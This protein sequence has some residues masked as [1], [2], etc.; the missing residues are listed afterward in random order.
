MYSPKDT[1]SGNILFN[2][3]PI[4]SAISKCVLIN[5]K[6]SSST[7]TLTLDFWG[8]GHHHAAFNAKRGLKAKHV[9]RY[10]KIKHEDWVMLKG[11]KQMRLS[12]VERTRGAASPVAS[13]GS[14]SHPASHLFRR[15]ALLL[16]PVWSSWKTSHMVLKVLQENLFL[17]FLVLGR[18]SQPFYTA[19]GGRVHEL[20]WCFPSILNKSLGYLGMFYS[21]DKLPKHPGR[22]YLQQLQ[23]HFH[24]LWRAVP[25]LL[26]PFYVWYLPESSGWD[27]FPCR[28]GRVLM[29]PVK[30]DLMYFKTF[31]TREQITA[32]KPT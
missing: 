26:V 6:I 29:Q 11:T 15:S 16:V 20:G 27:Q 3:N 12:L 5:I 30:G 32:S 23:K 7:V 8:H 10:G 13:E 14:S 2:G 4:C 31:E 24:R 28:K 17:S 25:C 19:Q 21:S 1:F 22:L 18:N 9:L